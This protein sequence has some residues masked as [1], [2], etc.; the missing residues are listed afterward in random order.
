MNTNVQ[1]RDM[2][3]GEAEILLKIGKQFFSPIERMGMPIPQNALVAAVD[4]NIAG[5]LFYKVFEGK[6]AA[7]VVYIDL[8]Y[9]VKEYRG[10][11]IGELLYHTGIERIKEQ[12]YE[13][14]TAMVADDNAASWKLFGKEGFER[15]SFTEM[16]KALGFVGS[17]K[18]WVHTIYCIS[19]GMNMWASIVA[20]SRKSWS[21]IATFLALNML[22]ITPFSIIYG[23]LNRQSPLPA[24]LAYLS[25]LAISI[26]SGFIGCLTV[27]ERWRFGFTRGGLLISLPLQLFG[28]I[29]PVM[30]RWYP[31]RFNKTKHNRKI[32]GIE[33]V[34]EW[35]GL[36]SFSVISLINSEGSIYWQWMNSFLNA[37]LFYHI[38]AIFPFAHFG[39][40]RVLNWSKGLYIL[41]V[42]LSLV[43][44]GFSLFR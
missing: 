27:K 2:L 32:L 16:V 17:L 4:G 41:L 24:L 19:C 33:A 26:V 31:S 25:V 39:G 5:A 13:T 44:I 1:L 30:G 37:M 38:A 40:R 22:L 23:H 43:Q 7:P 42:I 6:N 8:A 3:P 20:K 35:L 34:V 21:E 28:I 15:A 29:F 10:M 9:V 18:L 11:G 14:I 12:G 36:L